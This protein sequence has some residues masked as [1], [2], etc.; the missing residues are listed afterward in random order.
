MVIDIYIF[1]VD[2]S[3]NLFADDGS[4][5]N[6]VLRMSETQQQ[7][8]LDVSQ[9]EDAEEDI[10]VVKETQMFSKP[11]ASKTTALLPP[12]NRTKND[13]NVE[14]DDRSKQSIT[15]K[16]VKTKLYDYLKEDV[17]LPLQ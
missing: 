1:I 12:A 17:L 9:F 11:T 14:A 15:I 16:W 13:V 3:D 6:L 2:V 4:S 7:S 5:Q 10:I 8:Q